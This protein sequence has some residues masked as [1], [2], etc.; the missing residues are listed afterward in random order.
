MTRMLSDNH[1]KYEDRLTKLG[2]LQ[3][4]LRRDLIGVFKIIIRFGD[5]NFQNL[6][7]C[8]HTGRGHLYKFLNRGFYT[9]SVNIV[10]PTELLRNR[11][12]CFLKT[13]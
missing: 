7:Q 1:M 4:Q 6:F 10:F 3:R 13:Y 5:V 8:A 12:N 9:I 11:I 2:L